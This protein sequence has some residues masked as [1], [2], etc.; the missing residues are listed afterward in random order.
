M[1][2]LDIFHSINRVNK[3]LKHPKLTQLFNRFATYNG[4]NPYKASGIMT[5]IPHLEHGFGT[6]FLKGGMQSITNAVY[7]LAMDLGVDFHFNKK[8]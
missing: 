1:P 8:V 7:R 5:S 2:T 4:S 6:F 3:R